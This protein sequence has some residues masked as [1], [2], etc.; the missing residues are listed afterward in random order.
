M[1]SVDRYCRRSHLTRIRSLS[2][3]NTFNYTNVKKDRIVCRSSVF[4]GTCETL[5]N[6]A[7]IKQMDNIAPVRD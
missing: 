4:R 7:T 5:Y 2:K 1:A 3:R 6:S